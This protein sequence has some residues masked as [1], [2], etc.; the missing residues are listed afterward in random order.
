MIAM[1]PTTAAPGGTIVYDASSELDVPCGVVLKG[2]NPQALEF[3]LVDKNGVAL[4]IGYDTSWAIQIIIEW[5]QEVKKEYLM[6]DG[7][8]SNYY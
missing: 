4:N 8:G 3:K 2:Y 1:I 6:D 5:E 7:L